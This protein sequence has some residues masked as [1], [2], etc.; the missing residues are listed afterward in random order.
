MKESQ[1]TSIKVEK[2]KQTP[3]SIRLNSLK[4][5]LSNEFIN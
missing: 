2:I 5:Y 3:Q 4:F 1:V